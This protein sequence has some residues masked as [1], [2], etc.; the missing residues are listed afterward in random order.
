MD[1]TFLRQGQ[2]VWSMRCDLFVED[3]FCKVVW[4]ALC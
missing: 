4:L 2:F 3:Y 1:M